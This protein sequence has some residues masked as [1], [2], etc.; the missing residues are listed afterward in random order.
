MTTP[1]LIHQ[2]KAA[3]LTNRDIIELYKL[4]GRSGL[5]ALVG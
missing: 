2:L 4:A 3:G 5:E 1:Q